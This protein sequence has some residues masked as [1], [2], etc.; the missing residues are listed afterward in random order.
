[1]SPVN[2][3]SMAAMIGPIPNTSVTLVP[4]AATAVRIRL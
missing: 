4:D 2:P 1:M 3:M